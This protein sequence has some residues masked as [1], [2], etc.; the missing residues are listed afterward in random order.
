MIGIALCPLIST[1]MPAG[2]AALNR[3]FEPLSIAS[4]SGREYALKCRLPGLEGR[5]LA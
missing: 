3:A 1:G 2:N 5:H 4:A